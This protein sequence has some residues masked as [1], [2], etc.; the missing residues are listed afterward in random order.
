MEICN[1]RPQP[2]LHSGLALAIATIPIQPWETP[3]D[4]ATALREGTI[5][6]GLNM[7]FFVTADTRAVLS[8]A[9]SAT[10]AA[11]TRSDGIPRKGG[12]AHV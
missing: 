9:G 12:A 6:P 7:P 1:C 2:S 11:S 4:P 3:C 5:F 10:S 8:S